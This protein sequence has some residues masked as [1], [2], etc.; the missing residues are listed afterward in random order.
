MSITIASFPTSRYRTHNTTMCGRFALGVPVSPIHR[1][2]RTTLQP[3]SQASEIRAGIVHHFPRMLNN[4]RAAARRARAGAEERVRRAEERQ[5][6]R[7]RGA[8]RGAA[9]QASAARSSAREEVPP[10]EFEEED[11]A[12]EWPASDEDVAPAAA[13]EDEQALGAMLHWENEERFRQGNFNV[14]PRSNGVV[15]RLRP[16]SSDLRLRGGGEGGE[17]VEEKEKERGLLDI[18]D[19]ELVIETM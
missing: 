13:E 9:A 12:Y 16:S 1:T 11:E 19:Q 18:G 14:A 4:P 2:R 8:A 3:S 6:R 5:R 15:L 17:V 10:Q 7:G